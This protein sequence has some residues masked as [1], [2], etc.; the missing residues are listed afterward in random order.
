NVS[1][2]PGGRDGIISFETA[3]GEPNHLWLAG[4]RSGPR[5]Q[6]TSGTSSE[7]L[8]S[9][10]PDGKKILFL[11]GKSDFMIVSASLNDAAV[12]RVISSE[13]PTGM[14]AWSSLQKSFV[15]ESERG[16][17]PAIWMRSDGW[18]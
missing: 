5:R 15:Y 17:S 7:A 4:V 3:Q 11:T 9:V 16:G 13:K 12:E 8:P 18:D 2:L 14:P 10:S 1:W 6:I